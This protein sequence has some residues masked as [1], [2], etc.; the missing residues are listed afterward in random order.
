METSFPEL[1]EVQNLKIETLGEPQYDSPLCGQGRQFV[2][3]SNRV[4][5]YSNSADLAKCESCKISPP[6]F[7]GAGPREKIFY[8]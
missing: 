5:V 8:N 1:N 6:G 2:D 4:F 3:D 7:E